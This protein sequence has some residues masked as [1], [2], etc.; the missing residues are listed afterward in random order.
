LGNGIKF[1]IF[2]HKQVGSPLKRIIYFKDIRP[3]PPFFNRR[4][5]ISSLKIFIFLAAGFLFIPW[6]L[7]QTPKAPQATQQGRDPLKVAILPITIHSPESLEYLREGVYAMFSS[8]VEL[9]GRIMVLERAAVKKAVSQ[10]SGEIDSDAAKKLGETL[11]ADFVV[12]GSLTKLG[13]SASLD[14]KVLDVKGEKPPSSV[15]VQAKKLEEIIGQVD[16][17]AR[18]VDEKI[19]G[20]SIGPPQAERAAVAEKPSEAPKSTAAIPAPIPVPPPSLRP[21][22]PAK[23]E[24]GTIPS[25]GFWQSTPFSF[26]IQGMAMGDLDGDGRNEVVLIDER[27]LW[28]YRWENEFK[29]LKKISG[30]KMDKYLAVDAGDIDKNGRAEIFVTN[31]QGDETGWGHSRLAS[32]VVA[33][34]D[35][36]YRVVA[37]NL[38]W[39]L[40]VVSWGE[41]GTVLLGQSKGVNTS[42]EG[43]IYEMA[44]DGKAL[45]ETRK[46]EV[47]KVFSLYGFTPFVHEGK[48]HFVFID[49]D[50]RLKVIDQKGKMIWRSQ[51]TYGSDIAFRVKPIPTGP[52]PYEGDDLAFVN[53]RVIARG[54]EIFILRNLS[55][56]GQFFKRTKYYSGGEV[57]SLGWNGAMFMETWKSQEIPGYLVDFQTQ[58]LDGAPG[59]ELVVAVN[60]PKESLLSGERNSALMI[61]RMQ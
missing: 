58:D 17:L 26:K 44:W 4:G 19:L 28:I 16:V 1:A 56:V 45:K 2:P 21:V 36:D 41:K 48:V 34:K 33:Y 11:G 23:P 49:F 20:Y 31:F 32:F 57:Q 46:A 60:L 18:Q 27:N 15:Y 39:F 54:N 13:D 35:G 61:S 7:A 37:S 25:G 14:L 52:E 22:T 5:R 6:S 12:F 50:Y 30:N 29:L 9:E 51:A 10:F 3:L 24:R 55:L 43:P 8:R 42:F 59:T 53:V 47:S 38:D 40:R